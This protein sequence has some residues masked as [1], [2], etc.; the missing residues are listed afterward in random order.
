[1]NAWFDELGKRLAEAA[2][3]RG[4]SIEPPSLSSDVGSELLEL[5]RVTA[6][7]QERR[8]AP[9]A[10]YMAG[11]AAARIEAAGGDASPA[12]IAEI[13]RAVREQMEAEAEA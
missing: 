10:S 1:M 12:A 8:F 11:E 9:L 4:V 6:H 2:Q 3:R 7:T 5:A 13:I